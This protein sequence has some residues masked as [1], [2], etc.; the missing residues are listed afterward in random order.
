MF[1]TADLLD[2]KRHEGLLISKQAVLQG[3]PAGRHLIP[4]SLEEQ[5]QSWVCG[6]LD[7]SSCYK[8]GFLGPLLGFY[9]HIARFTVSGKPVLTFSGL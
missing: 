9:Q 3:S 7:R 1:F 2:L 8:L 4:L 6:S 5:S